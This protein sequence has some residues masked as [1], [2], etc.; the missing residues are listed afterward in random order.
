V[1]GPFQSVV[2]AS[3]FELLEGTYDIVNA[4]GIVGVVGEVIKFG[5]DSS[6][7]AHE[8]NNPPMVL[9]CVGVLVL[10]LLLPL[11]LPPLPLP[12]LPL[13]LVPLPLRVLLLLLLLK[14]LS[15]GGGGACSFEDD[16]AAGNYFHPALRRFRHKKEYAADAR[17]KRDKWQPF[18]K[19]QVCRKFRG[20]FGGRTM[21]GI[22]TGFCMH[23][24]CYFFS[25][26]RD[27]EG[28]W[29]CV[30]GNGGCSSHLCW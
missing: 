12:L 18:N 8:I 28:V 15:S 30:G 24:V 9:R 16:W 3:S 14:H 1:D 25:F 13:L 6:A 20:R 29:G 2:V 23:G 5:K 17:N 7:H 26:M 4:E 22:F 19:N 21:P 27:N 11:L 10:L